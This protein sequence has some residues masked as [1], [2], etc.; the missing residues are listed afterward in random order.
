MSSNEKIQAF[1]TLTNEALEDAKQDL[2]F[3]TEEGTVKRTSLEDFA[4]IRTSGIIAISLKDNDKLSFAGLVN[5]EDEILITTAQG[6]SIRFE[7]SDI[8]PMGRSAGGVSGIKLSKHD[9]YVVGS[10]V[11][12]KNT[13]DLVLL[14]VAQ[15]GYGKKTDISEYKVQK[16]SGSGIRTYKVT[17]KTGKLV[18]AKALIN[19]SDTDLLIATESGKMLRLESREVP[20]LGRDTQ[21]VRLMKMDDGDKVTSV[22]LLAESVAE[23]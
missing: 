16:R 5:S 4:N 23:E 6:Q 2:F 8:R 12:N 22:E 13:K 21:G 1:V 19:K 11:I 15:M 3:V 9:D 17:D 14:T 10:V 7:V 18:G 20:V